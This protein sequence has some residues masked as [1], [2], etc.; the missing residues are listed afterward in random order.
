MSKATKI[1]DLD[2][3]GGDASRTITIGGTEY[4][5]IEMEF[6]N[7]IET[8]KEAQRLQADDKAT[9]TDH[10]EASVA[11][12][13]RSIPTLPVEVLRKLPVTKLGVIVQFL[14]GELDAEM[15][16]AAAEAAEAGGAEAKK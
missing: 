5:V 10:M 16:K 8:T 9:V 6:E 1:L 15:D 2:K 3:F 4:P 14:N 13:Q 7:F 12:I 11:M